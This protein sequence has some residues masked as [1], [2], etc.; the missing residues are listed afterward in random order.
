MVK[1][2]K[3]WYNNEKKENRIKS[4]VIK[5]DSNLFYGGIKLST[6]FFF[7]SSGFV[8]L[9]TRFVCR[10][11]YLFDVFCRTIGMGY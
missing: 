7:F 9:W 2:R 11:T 1:N 3:R 6:K 8:F 10:F 5:N 4:Q